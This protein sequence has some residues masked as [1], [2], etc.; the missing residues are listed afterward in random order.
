MK[1]LNDAHF[2]LDMLPYCEEGLNESKGIVTAGEKRDT[3][4]YKY[5]LKGTYI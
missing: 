4:Y 3:S 2:Y 1:N 5:S